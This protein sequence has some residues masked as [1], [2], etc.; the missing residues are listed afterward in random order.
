[1]L[2]LHAD[3]SIHRVQFGGGGQMRRALGIMLIV[4]S[5]AVSGVVSAAVRPNHGKGGHSCY[6]TCPTRTDLF[7]WPF[8]VS[9]GNEQ[10]V[11]FTVIVHPRFPWTPGT[12][13]GSASVMSQSTTLCLITLVGGTGSCSPSSD[14][15]P[16]S[17]QP[18]FITATY[19]GDT[20]FSPSTSRFRLLK[21]TDDHGHH[22]HHHWWGDGA[23]RASARL[24]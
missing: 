3:C 8:T 1:M 15:L 2:A 20:N 22:H 11:V 18:Y 19:G 14:A 7:V 4:G 6:S 13:T 23:A 16:A 9:Y 17:H 12:P 5:L 21:V 10:N 24:G